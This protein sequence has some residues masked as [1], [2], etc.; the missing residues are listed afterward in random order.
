MPRTPNFSLLAPQE[1]EE[2]EPLAVALELYGGVE[3]EAQ[4]KGKLGSGVKEATVDLVLAWPQLEELLR[5]CHHKGRWGQALS[6]SVLAR[7]DG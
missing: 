3:T 1:V 4:V 5:A 6:C 2:P 7:G